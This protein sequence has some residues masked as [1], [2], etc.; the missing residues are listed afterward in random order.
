VQCNYSPNFGAQND[1]FE[2]WHFHFT[3]PPKVV[4]EIQI[5]HYKMYLRRIWER[6]GT[7]R[8]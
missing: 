7:A 8:E 4:M 5:P 3:S 1:H 6:R 2:E